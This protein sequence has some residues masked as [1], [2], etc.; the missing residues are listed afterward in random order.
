MWL[1]ALSGGLAAPTARAQPQTERRLPAVRCSVPPAIDG[2]LSD[3]AWQEAPVATGFA[4]EFSGATDIDPTEARVCY[5][6]EAIY[7]AFRCH[8]SQPNAIVAREIRRNAEFEG[9]DTVTFVLDPY[10][11]R[12]GDDMNWFTVNALG[13]GRAELAGGRARKVEWEGE[14]TSAARRTE[15]GWEAELRIPWAMLSYP[16]RRPL[17]MG[18]N[19][20][21]RQERTR[22]RSHWSFLGYRYRWEQSGLWEGVEPPRA[23]FRPTLSLLPYASPGYLWGRGSRLR[24]GLD[25]RLTLTPELTGVATLNPDFAS[26]EGAVEGIEFSRS[27]RFVPE[28][29]PFFLEGIELFGT[30]HQLVYTRR[31]VDPR[32]GVKVTGKLGGLGVAYLSALDDAAG[33]AGEDVAVHVARLRRDIG[34]S[35]VAGAAR[36]PANAGSGAAE[37]G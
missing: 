24:A 34:A 4:D 7:V 37:K 21:R 23:A 19:F 12:R 25:A 30:P 35:S 9:E 10:L 5:D 8:D 14:W 27:E 6:D 1:V 33:P 29:R 26:V 17:T 15:T 3:P 11:A 22:L 18:I 32:A 13:T 36:N 2:D 31:I 28:T 20:M 16:A